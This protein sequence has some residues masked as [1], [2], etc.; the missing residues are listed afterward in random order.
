MRTSAA[1][2]LVFAAAFPA[3]LLAGS[4]CEAHA[5][6][7]V[8]LVEGLKAQTGYDTVDAFMADKA[9]RWSLVAATYAYAA[10]EIEAGNREVGPMLIQSD[11]L[12]DCFKGDRASA[13]PDI[14]A[15]MDDF[16][17]VF[18]K[19]RRAKLMKLAGQE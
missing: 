13:T 19:T 12:L 7:W 17:Q 10:E 3:P 5:E 2:P 16:G 4:E 18:P 14:K 8:G 6:A 15:Y 1:L 9:G 11:A